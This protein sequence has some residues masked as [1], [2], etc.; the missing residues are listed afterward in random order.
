MLVRLLA[1]VNGEEK[2][3]VR[4]V[5]IEQVHLAKVEM[6]G[7]DE[8]IGGAQVDECADIQPKNEV[9]DDANKMRHEDQQ[10]ELVEP[11]RLFPLR[12]SIV[13]P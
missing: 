1:W 10:D 5:G 11:D 7:N 8:N 6:I 4:V 12:G 13:V 2:R 9:G 3:Q